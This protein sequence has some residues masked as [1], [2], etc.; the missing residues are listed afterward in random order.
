[1]AT[2]FEDVETRSL[3]TTGG[4]VLRQEGALGLSVV[5]MTAEAAQGVPVEDSPVDLIALS[6]VPLEGKLK[7]REKNRKLTGSS[8]IRIPL[9]KL[10]AYPPLQTV[11]NDLIIIDV[12]L[13]EEVPELLIAS[14]DPDSKNGE[15]TVT[16]PV[17]HLEIVE[18]WLVEE[19]S[20]GC[21]PPK[22]SIS[23]SLITWKKVQPSGYRRKWTPVIEKRPRRLQ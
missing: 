7:A 2:T 14:E 16:I 18:A 6:M 10:N 8:P 20:I 15:G 4:D 23:L 11:D 19:A 22:R 5:Q 13:I 3:V 21:K 1:M 12:P 17:N 9:E